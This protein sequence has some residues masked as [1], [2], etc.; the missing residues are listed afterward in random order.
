MN[1]LTTIYLNNFI[2]IRVIPFLPSVIPRRQLFLEVPNPLLKFA[3]LSVPVR[4]LHILLNDFFG[5]KHA[6]NGVSQGLDSR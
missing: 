6:G 2:F 4:D 1:R 5:Y 3:D